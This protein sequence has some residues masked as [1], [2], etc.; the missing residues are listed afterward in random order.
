MEA[1]ASPSQQRWQKRI[2]AL[3]WV[4]YALS[5]LCRTKLSIALPE[6]TAQLHWS[7]AGKAPLPFG[8][9]CVC[10]ARLPLLWVRAAAQSQ[11][12]CPCTAGFLRRIFYGKQ[13]GS[14]LGR[15]NAPRRHFGV[16]RTLFAR[17]SGAEQ[18]LVCSKNGVPFHHTALSHVF[19]F[20]GSAAA[21]RRSHQRMAAFCASV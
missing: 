15:R 12:N 13:S 1:V 3:C 2:L 6:M 4:S 11:R 17:L 5:Y 14:C 20:W 8:W 21:A 19:V 10:S 9:H 18:R 16:R 7:A